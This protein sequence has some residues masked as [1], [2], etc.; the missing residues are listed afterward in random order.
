SS[1]FVGVGTPEEATLLPERIIATAAAAEQILALIA[2]SSICVT[3]FRSR[4]K[5]VDMLSKWPRKTM[6][7]EISRLDANAILS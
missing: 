3:L 1:G 4:R 2:L 7:K 5:K 6:T